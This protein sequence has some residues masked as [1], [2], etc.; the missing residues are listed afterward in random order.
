MPDFN[1]RLYIGE[2]D[3]DDLK[4]VTHRSRYSN[5]K[6]IGKCLLLLCAS[7]LL[8]I[9][10]VRGVQPEL[11]PEQIVQLKSY[12]EE[13]SLH[14]TF[15]VTSAQ[16]GDTTYRQLM[17]RDRAIA[18][19]YTHAEGGRVIGEHTNRTEVPAVASAKKLP[20]P[21]AMAS[22]NEIS[23]SRRLYQPKIVPDLQTIKVLPLY[24]VLADK[25]A[26]RKLP[27]PEATVLKIV[28]KHDRVTLF[29]TDGKWAQVAA[30]DGTGVTGYLLQSSIVSVTP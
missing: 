4:E 18:E 19:G 1:R 12:G 20:L 26:I 15:H 11:T 5:V 14:Q 10:L 28:S 13:R 16:T 24:A 17:Q 3:E 9:M 25:V 6:I 8:V 21:A 29:S 22:P 30:N 7:L 2:V 23:D 27:S